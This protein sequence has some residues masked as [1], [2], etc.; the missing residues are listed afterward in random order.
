MARPPDN[1][2]AGTTTVSYAAL[3]GT[4]DKLNDLAAQF[5]NTATE[6]GARH[7][8]VLAGAG[9]FRGHL[10]VGAVKFLIAWREAFTVCGQ[11]AGLMVANTHNYSM[12]LR[13]VDVDQQVKVTI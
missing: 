5:Q 2:L 8:Q 11:S 7:D 6:V 3:D 12:D 4:R 9:E 1:D 10:E 13:A